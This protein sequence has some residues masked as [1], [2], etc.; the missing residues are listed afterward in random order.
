MIGVVK[1]ISVVKEVSVENSFKAILFSNGIIEIIFNQDIQTVEEKHIAQIR[2]VVYELGGGKKMP[3]FLSSGDF[4][5]IS[6]EGRKYAATEEVGRYTLANAVLIDNLAKKLI[7]NFFLNLNKPKTPT[8][9]FST[10]N[11]AFEW[12]EKLHKENQKLG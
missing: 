6:D 5:N 3:V 10:R 11:D 4:V 8:K 7:F 9:G 12:L 2:Q 1:N